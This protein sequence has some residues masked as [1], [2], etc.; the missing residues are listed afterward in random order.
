MNIIQIVS[1]VC[2]ALC[3]I[4]FFYLK[5]FVKKRTSFSG[6]EERQSELAKLI[7]EIDRITDRDSQLVEDR[8]N[9]LKTILNDVDRRIAVLEKDI[10]ELNEL[11]KN[12]KNN[13]VKESETSLYTSLGR[14]I[15]A[16]L[17]TPEQAELD[18]VQNELQKNELLTAEQ[19]PIAQPLPQ[20]TKPQTA[21]NPAPQPPQEQRAPSKKQ[22]RTHIDLLVNEGVSAQEIANRLNISIAEVNLAMNLR[23]GK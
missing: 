6:L 10:E 23:R 15:R 19:P 5:W 9:K 2:F 7:A 18:L 1:I 13:N 22:I 8:V 14:G 17:K 12:K 3:F 21:P 4:M 20:P 16:A 11:S